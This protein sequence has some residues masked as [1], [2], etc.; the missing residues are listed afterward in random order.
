MAFDEIKAVRENKILG[1]LNQIY[2][3]EK[4]AGIKFI[5]I[6]PAIINNLQL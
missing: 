6:H 2:V 4:M 3:Q 5:K 1:L